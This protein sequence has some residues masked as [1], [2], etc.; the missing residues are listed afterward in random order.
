MRGLLIAITCLL[1]LPGA[2]CQDVKDAGSGLKSAAVDCTRAETLK[3]AG[4][5]GPVVEHVL[6]EAVTPDGHIDWAPVK[7]LAK[8]FTVDVGGCVLASVVARVLHPAPASPGAPQSSPLAI[9]R[10]ALR[11]GFGKLKGELFGGVTFRTPD[12]EL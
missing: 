10:E 8:G 7:D 4:E 3:V 12:G 11:A 9:D 2:A 6:T 1:F 5:L